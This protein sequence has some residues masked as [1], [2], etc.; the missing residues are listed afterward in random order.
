MNKLLFTLFPV[1]LIGQFDQITNGLGL[2]IGSS[3][4]GLF[5]GRQYVHISGVFAVNG[6]IRLYDIKAE[7]ETIVYD[8]YT[9]QYK[10]VGGKSLFMVPLFTG[11]NYY[12]FVGKIE[13]NFAPFIGLKAGAVFTA[14]GEEYGTF[15]QRWKNPKTQFTPGGFLGIGIDFMLAGRSSVAVMVGYEYLPL[16]EISDGKN[17]Y[18]GFLIHV[19]FNRISK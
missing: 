13:N 9:G 12:P 4:S 6:E 14:D 8:Y 10:T 17:D 16:K 5:I 2:D 11:V 1:L 7:E 3:G 15:R 18:S 19:S